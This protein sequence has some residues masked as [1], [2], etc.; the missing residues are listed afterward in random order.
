M[1]K[2]LGG[3]GLG[4]AHGLTVAGPGTVPVTITGPSGTIQAPGLWGPTLAHG[5]HW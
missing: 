2:L 5:S 3:V 1:Y 4:L